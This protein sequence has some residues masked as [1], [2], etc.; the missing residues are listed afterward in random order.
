[1]LR[2]VVRE[3]VDLLSTRAPRKVLSRSSSSRRWVRR[4][5]LVLVPTL[6]FVSINA[7]SVGRASKPDLVVF[8]PGQEIPLLPL[9]PNAPRLVLAKPRRVDPSLFRLGVTTVVIDPGHG[10]ADPG[11]LTAFGLTEKEITL[12]VSRRLRDLLVQA[13]FKVEMTRDQDT[14][15]SLKDR[16]QFA[17]GH[18]ADLFVS[19]H[20]NS[21]PQA[22]RRLVETY[23]LGPSDD[24]R[25]DALVGEENRGSG[26]T[27]TS[28]KKLLDGIYADVRQSE[29]KTFALAVQKELFASLRKGNPALQDHG[30]KSAP[31]V[32][33]IATEMPG[34]LAEVSCISNEAEARNLSH[35]AYRQSI[36]QALYDGLH[37]YA[38]ERSPVPSKGS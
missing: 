31:F 30:V 9:D 24:P 32:V 11:A 38:E 34:I 13:R 23:Y 15:V 27:M 10:G 14:T 2:E 33:L 1:M 28:F 16:A 26:Y 5:A 18:S 6:L 29:S 25:V 37:A 8:S 19:V 36:A 21:V 35:P 3:N 4:S 22:D 17:N 20:V 7:I 12:D